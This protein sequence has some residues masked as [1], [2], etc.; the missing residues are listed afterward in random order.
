MRI[1]EGPTNIDVCEGI[2]K[3]NNGKQGSMKGSGGRPDSPTTKRPIINAYQSSTSRPTVASGFPKSHGIWCRFKSAY[4]APN[5]AHVLTKRLIYREV[6]LRIGRER[7]S[8][9]TV[10]HP[11]RHHCIAGNHSGIQ[12]HASPILPPPTG[13][14][15]TPCRDIRTC[16]QAPDTICVNTIV[17]GHRYM[18]YSWRS[19]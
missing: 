13:D 19:S 12:W 14:A 17:L 1:P 10:D 15:A 16:E 7:I 11:H 6:G 3:N 2:H 8:L 18:L 5:T 9:D 4:R